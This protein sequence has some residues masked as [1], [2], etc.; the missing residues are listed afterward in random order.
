MLSTL[1]RGGKTSQ[2]KQLSLEIH[3]FSTST[4]SST[5][6]VHLCLQTFSRAFTSNLSLPMPLTVGGPHLLFSQ[7]NESHHK[8]SP[9]LVPQEQVN[10]AAHSGGGSS[11]SKALLSRWAF[12]YH[13]RNLAEPSEILSLSQMLDFFLS[14]Y[15]DVSISI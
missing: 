10:L 4:W 6:S 2:N 7:E 5:L 11:P 15:C 1:R 3:G 12:S 13:P 14:F 9:Q 8:C